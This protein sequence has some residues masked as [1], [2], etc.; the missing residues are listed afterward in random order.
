MFRRFPI[1]LLL[2]LSAGCRPT[3]PAD[4]RDENQRVVTGYVRSD[5][6]PVSEAVV[7]F[8]GCQSHVTTDSSGQFLLP[9]PDNHVGQS[10]TI[11]ASKSGYLIAGARS[12]DEPVEIELESLP[13]E[14]NPDYEWVDP[15]PD[16]MASHN[17]GNCHAEIF[18]E[19]QTDGHA[20][21]AVN[22][23]FLGL[24]AGHDWQGRPNH[25]WNLLE[26]HPHGAGVCTACHAPAATMDELA[27]ADIRELG[28]IA[29]LGVHCDFCHK[30]QGVS[31][32]EIGLTHG[33]FGMELLRPTDGQLFFGPLDDVDR[34]DDTFSELQTQS[35]YCASCHEGIVFGVHVYSTYS[36]WL[37]SPAR[38]QGKQCQSCH[39]K[40]TG[41]LTNIAPSAGGIERDP[42]TL[43]SHRFMSEGHE[44][45]L[46]RCLN[47]ATDWSEDGDGVALTVSIQTQD[48]GHRV[49]TGFIDRHLLLVVEGVDD[50]QQSVQIVEGPR[51]PSVAGDFS[52]LAG[53]L[54]AKRIVD[55][56][57]PDPV[58]FWRAAG[59]IVDT[60]L[61]PEDTH[62]VTFR[63]PEDVRSARVRLV[64]RGFWYQVARSKDWPLDDIMI[65][66]VHSSR[67]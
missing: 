46:R 8:K 12:T 56:S 26:D 27:T 67:P 53:Q 4:S 9:W 24:Y 57:S 43:A 3:S 55:P 65:H 36:E 18:K 5:G 35:A 32:R 44:S 58:P 31:Q 16:P 66:D 11:T 47:V 59:D 60:R 45:M 6:N 1:Y 10:E 28:G 23:R 51:L 50:Q 48:V 40:P 49:P 54:F 63:Y 42:Q 14:D 17:C 37:E 29:K 13:T 33:R 41:K 34:G 64:Y 20:S 38:K 39:M 2:I 52:D 61:R 62:H 19:W 7:R 22:R 15:R 21:A 30:V 25:G